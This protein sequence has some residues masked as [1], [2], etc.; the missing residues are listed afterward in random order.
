MLGIGI[1][2]LVSSLAMASSSSS[3]KVA[4]VGAGAV[5]SY[6]GARLWQGGQC[7]VQFHMRGE[8]GRVSLQRGLNVTV[9]KVSSAS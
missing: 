8:H 6:Y 9:S 7:R 2:R 5:G 4:V 1:R 3:T